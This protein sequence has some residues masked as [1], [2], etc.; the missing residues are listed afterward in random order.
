M[1]RMTLDRLPDSIAKADNLPSPPGVA[2]QVMRLAEDPNARAEDLGALIRNDPALTIRLLRTVNSA[3]N[4]LPQTIDSVE[5][6]CAL[7]GFRQAKTLALGFAVADSLPVVGPE[8]GFDLEE[9]WLRSG[10][11]ATAAEV[12]ARHV[13]PQH[14][15]LAFVVGLLSEVGRLVLASCLTSTYKTVTARES[16]PS[17]RLEREILGFS[18]LDLSSA[19]YTEWHL[20]SDIVDP[21]AYRDNPSE[22]PDDAS[23]DVIR[24][25]RI[26][27]ASEILAGVWA[28]GAERR[29]LNW[30]SDAAW[31]YLHLPAEDFVGI[32]DELKYRI[33]REGAFQTVSPPSAV[34]VKSLEEQ[35]TERLKEAVGRSTSG[36]RVAEMLRAASGTSR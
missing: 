34:N 35:A 20:P 15:D 18:N 12:F 6:A 30:A 28:S 23:T 27:A 11:T 8:S 26:L 7:L 14:A 4:G 22:L 36:S 32:V 29:S 10:L 16:W 5:R 24:L 31:H 25:C 13:S 21:I 2:L 9:Y 17:T 3:A 1:S 33:E 19:M